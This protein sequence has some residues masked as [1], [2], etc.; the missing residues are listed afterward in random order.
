MLPN[1][2]ESSPQGTPHQGPLT[3]PVE[4]RVLIVDDDR[5]AVAEYVESVRLLRYE[6]YAAHDAAEAL[7]LIAT[8]PQIGIVVSDINMPGM[9][10]LSLLDEI[11]ARFAAS[12]DIVTLVITGFGGLDMA[13]QAMRHEAIDFLRKP[14]N[15]EELAAALRRAVRRWSRL[16]AARQSGQPASGDAADEAEA[17]LPSGEDETAM[18]LATAKTLIRLRERRGEFLD[19]DLFADPVWDIMLDLTSATLEGKATP[20]SSVCQAAGVPM[21]TALRHIRHLV[22]SGLVR[23]WQ[24]PNDRRRDLLELLPAA[25]EAM[26]GYMRTAT[27]RIGLQGGNPG[28]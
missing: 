20:V 6:A 25:R 10:G 18:L 14:V 24:D 21:S 3:P 8:D 7:R 16:H 19:P 11:A 13:V 12:R 23:R 26:L 1:N 22:D 15:P 2:D 17:L 27:R 5:D 28:R 9:D 4:C